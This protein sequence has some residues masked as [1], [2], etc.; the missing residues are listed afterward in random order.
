MTAVRRQRDGT[1]VR[2]SR[3]FELK[4]VKI[5]ARVRALAEVMQYQT[6]VRY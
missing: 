6:L 4:P 5:Q 2:K 1:P 3:S